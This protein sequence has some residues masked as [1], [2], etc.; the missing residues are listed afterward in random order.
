MANIPARSAILLFLPV[1]CF[2]AP[3][4]PIS[5]YTLEF[6]CLSI[7]SEELKGKCLQ[8]VRSGKRFT[9]DKTTMTQYEA[10]EITQAKPRVAWD[11][12]RSI[13]IVGEDTTRS[14]TYSRRPEATTTDESLKSIAGS[15]R[16][17]AVLMGVGFVAGIVSFVFAS[18]D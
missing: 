9:F 10:K 12:V 2:C 11:T 14:E 7:K 1:F 15:L 8:A 5:I 18:N 3:D 6:E 16:F 17:M 4:D 13:S